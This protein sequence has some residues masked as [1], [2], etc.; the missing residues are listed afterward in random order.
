[1][2]DADGRITGMDVGRSTTLFPAIAALTRRGV[3][4]ERA[5]LP[6][7][8]NVAALLRLPR[9]GTL[10]EGSDADLVVLGDDLAPERVMARGA[11]L[12]G[13]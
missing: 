7:T 9:K 12:A 3:T 6:F 10:A 8:A 13:R 2:F 4:L 11:W 1:M 5:L